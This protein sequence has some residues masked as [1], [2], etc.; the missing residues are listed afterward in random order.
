MCERGRTWLG[1]GEKRMRQAAMYERPQSKRWTKEKIEK[2]K[3][4]YIRLVATLYVWF[5]HL[6]HRCSCYSAQIHVNVGLLIDD[7]WWATNWGSVL[8]QN[9][10]D[11]HVLA[12]T[13]TN[14]KWVIKNGWDHRY[15]MVLALENDFCKIEQLDGY[16]TMFESPRTFWLWF[17]LCCP[18][19]STV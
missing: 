7:V 6:H 18:T 8:F 17:I 10:S 5:H 2:K 1:D 3:I 12:V 13:S 16:V 4:V 9:R 11:W 15:L 19:G 14:F